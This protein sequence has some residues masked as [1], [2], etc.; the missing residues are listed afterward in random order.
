M[1][2]EM[3]QDMASPRMNQTSEIVLTQ[4]QTLEVI[5]ARRGDGEIEVTN[6]SI[7][8]EGDLGM[9]GRISFDST[10]PRDRQ[11]ARN[12]PTLAPFA[13]LVGKSFTMTLNEAGEVRSLEN[14]GDLAAA[15]GMTVAMFEAQVEQLWHVVPGEAVEVGE[16]WST[17]ST[18]AIPGV[19]EITVELDFEFVEMDT[20]EGLDVAVIEVTGQASMG[21]GGRIA[22]M[23]VDI[24]ESVVE[25]VIHFAPDLGLVIE[26]EMTQDLVLEVTGQ[27]QTITQSMSTTAFVELSDVQGL[28][29]DALAEEPETDEVEEVEPADEPAP[30]PAPSN[31]AGGRP[32]GKP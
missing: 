3:T 2:V 7:K 26:S 20:M 23:R 13:G 17:R 32:G 4:V 1:R 10:N 11:R 22:G 27:G 14:A 15:S 25:G 9:A 12:D 5:G 18:Q 28:D 30:A 8:V 21:R 31:P 16:T 29:L 19:G 24:T 6:E